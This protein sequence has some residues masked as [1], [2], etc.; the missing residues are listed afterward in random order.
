MCDFKTLEKIAREG[1][2]FLIEDAAQ[3]LGSIKYGRKSGTFGIASVF[4]FHRTKTLCTGEGG[5]M[6]TDDTQLY[7]RCKFL[8]DHGRQPGTYY[9]TEVTYKYVP[10]NIVAALGYAQL[11][12][13]DELITIKRWQQQVYEDALKGLPVAMNYN[14]GEPNGAWVNGVVFAESTSIKKVDAMKR[15][16]D[17][18]VPSRPFFWPLSSLPAFENFKTGKEPETNPT[19][20][21]LSDRGINLP[22]AMNLTEVDL[23]FVADGVRRLFNDI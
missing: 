23:K 3:S 14:Y 10:S 11:L 12:R 4:S 9:N 7:N 22:C 15:L 1:N 2:M 21:S 6:V 16:S 5:M 20:Y 13:I 17:M 8:R 19:A 18:N